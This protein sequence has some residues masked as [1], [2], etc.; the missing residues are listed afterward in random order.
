[1]KNGKLNKSKTH[2]DFV[3]ELEL[4]NEYYSD[5]CFSVVGKYLNNRDKILLRDK[6]GF[7]EMNGWSLLCNNKPSISN[8]IDKTEYYKNM[9]LE[10]NTHYKNG[11]FK[12]IS[13]YEKMSTKITVENRFGICEAVAQVFVK[14]PPSIQSAIDKTAYFI[15]ECREIHGDT[16]SYDKVNYIG[17][18]KPVEIICPIH[19]SFK[20]QAQAH[21]S[22]Q[23]CYNCNILLN[24]YSKSEWI[25]SGNSVGMLYMLEFF[26]KDERFI[27]IGITKN[28]IKKRYSNKASLGYNYKM[29]DYVESGNKLLIWDSELNLKKK[30]KSLNYQ[31]LHKFSGSSTECFEYCDKVKQEFLRIKENINKL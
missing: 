5:G 6:F 24:R 10:N 2:E 16:Y 26:D 20:Q 1:M 19:G 7:M 4:K 12:I 17:S 9:L 22:G 11:E 31:P 14:F 25:E 18:N 28:S 8:A 30:L 23:G 27:K 21:K 15:A 29:I 3:K 13:E